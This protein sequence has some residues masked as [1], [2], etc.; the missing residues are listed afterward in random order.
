MGAGVRKRGGAVASL[1][2]GVGILGFVAGCGSDDS[3]EA[4]IHRIDRMCGNAYERY[5]KLPRADLGD[6]EVIHATTRNERA[7][8]AGLR[9]LDAPRGDEPAVERLARLLARQADELDEATR[10]LGYPNLK[11]AEYEIYKEH[12]LRAESLNEEIG[13]AARELGASA[14][15][16]PPVRAIYL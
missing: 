5:R 13:K 14:C 9:A 15:A 1:L 10:I 3:H 8:V 12:L 16:R 6:H 7:L 2:I 4:L 11:G